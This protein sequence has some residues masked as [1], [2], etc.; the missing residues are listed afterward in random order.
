VVIRVAGDG[1]RPE[2]LLTG[3]TLFASSIGR[4]D[5]AGGS[6]A[7]ELESIRDRILSRPDGAVVLPGHGASTTVLAE[8]TGNPFLTPAAL[9]RLHAAGGSSRD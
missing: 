4:T 2:I 5:L 9:A 8:R 1:D 3:D 7:Q 6:A